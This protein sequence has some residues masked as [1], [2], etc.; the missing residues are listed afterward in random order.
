MKRAHRISAVLL[1]VALSVGCQSAFSQG[2]PN[3]VILA[4]A[5]R[6]PGPLPRVRNRAI[7]RAR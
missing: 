5:E 3:I 2:E 6:S 1:A 4:R 7:P